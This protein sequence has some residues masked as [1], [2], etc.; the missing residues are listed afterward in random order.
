LVLELFDEGFESGG[1]L[2]VKIGQLVDVGD[3]SAAHDS[4]DCFL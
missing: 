3:R 1:E 2:A 4:G